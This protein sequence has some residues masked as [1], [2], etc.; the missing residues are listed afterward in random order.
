[1]F[2]SWLT[3]ERVSSCVAALATGRIEFVFTG[4]EVRQNERRQ[5]RE[6]QF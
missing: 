2:A 4:G 5:C 1:M 6:P 3:T